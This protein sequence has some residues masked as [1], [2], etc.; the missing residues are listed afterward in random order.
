MSGG[1]GDSSEV[2]TVVPGR[3]RLQQARL[4]LTELFVCGCHWPLLL[5]LLNATVL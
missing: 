1:K 5:L 2:L 4:L 3:G